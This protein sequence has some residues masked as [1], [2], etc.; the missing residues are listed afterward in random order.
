M[1]DFSHLVGD[2]KSHVCSERGTKGC[3]RV[4]EGCR[5]VLRAVEG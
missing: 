5:G 3:R 1:G 2:F 4:A